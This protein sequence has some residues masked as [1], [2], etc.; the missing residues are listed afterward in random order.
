MYLSTRVKCLRL[1]YRVPLG[2]V[3]CG[4]VRDGGIGL[5][6]RISG[7]FWDEFTVGERDRWNVGGSRLRKEGRRK[8][9]REERKERRG[10]RVKGLLSFIKNSSKTHRPHNCEVSIIE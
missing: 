8:G 7:K 4:K 1:P 3:P 2:C 5:R 9:Q 10:E 6:L